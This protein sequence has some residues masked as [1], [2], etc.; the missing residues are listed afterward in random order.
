MEMIIIVYLMVYYMYNMFAEVDL[1][2]KP[3]NC[4]DFYQLITYDDT[5]NGC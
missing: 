5:S 4:L 3:V 1:R 2:W